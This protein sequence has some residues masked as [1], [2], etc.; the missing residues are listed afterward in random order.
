MNPK[1]ITGTRRLKAGGEVA[2]PDRTS[3][4]PVEPTPFRFILVPGSYAHRARLGIGGGR[5]DRRR[6]THGATLAACQSMPIWR[7]TVGASS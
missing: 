1:W 6:A 3:P 4:L 5:S 7:V 2:I